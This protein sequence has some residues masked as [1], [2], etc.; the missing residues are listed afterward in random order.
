[1]ELTDDFINSISLN[2][3]SNSLL[4]LY[5]KYLNKV[6]LSI[7]SNYSFYE[8]V[9]SFKTNKYT[10]EYL[11]KLL[12]IVFY[13]KFLFNKFFK[14]L[15]IILQKIFNEVIFDDEPISQQQMS[16]RLDERVFFN[17][18]NPSSDFGIIMSLFVVKSKFGDYFI[19]LPMPIKSV[20]RNHIVPYTSLTHKHELIKSSTLESGL[21]TYE[22]EGKILDD[23]NNY[24]FHLKN[25]DISFDKF[26]RISKTSIN[27]IRKDSGIDEFFQEKDKK[28][29][30]VKTE[31]IFNFLACTKIDPLFK[32]PLQIIQALFKNYLDYKTKY[33]S[34]NLLTY[35]N[36]STAFIKSGGDKVKNNSF[37]LEM[38]NI[39]KCLPLEQ[40]V[41]FDDI[42]E[43]AQSKKLNLEILSQRDARNLC[44][45]SNGVT[46]YMDTERAFKEGLI[47]PIIK[48]SLFLFASFGL[49][50]IA[51]QEPIIKNMFY[52]CQTLKYVKLTKLGNFIIGNQKEYL[53]ESKKEKCE[54]SL[55]DDNLII[56]FSI[57]DRIKSILMRKFSEELNQ[58][59]FRVTYK[60]F[61]SDCKTKKDILDKIESFKEQVSSILNPLWR[62][63][64]D[65]LILKSDLLKENRSML[66]FSMTKN[67]ELIKLITR[68]EILKKYVLKVENFK[69]AIF[70]KDLKVVSERL[71]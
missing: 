37:H 20:L 43:Y 36:F 22:N 12:T 6:E 4:E 68:D 24:Y 49:I 31:L 10:R 70:Q 7:P 29:D 17:V 56:K 34:F 48:S 35:L 64:F 32:S 39:L 25:K 66:V 16:K 41:A 45:T 14:L 13:D 18:T 40:W 23:I 3:P 9:H 44:F 59:T 69:L 1:M 67:D 63:F 57:E 2:Y 33:L 53:Y 26:E 47:R 71:L 8:Q 27:N 60:S 50:D 15:P 5:K 38:F 42:F 58:K 46:E 11:L 65:E 62:Q 54:I 51:Y 55:D 52:P 21:L 61:L 30:S 28:I 19:E